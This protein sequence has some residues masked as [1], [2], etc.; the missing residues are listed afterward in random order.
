MNTI[1]LLALDHTHFNGIEGAESNTTLLLNR[2]YLTLATMSTAGYGNLSPKSMQAR[3]VL[4]CLM[5]VTSLGV[6]TTLL[7]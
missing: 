7:D 4:G 1:L 3:L 5:F 2:A 6:L